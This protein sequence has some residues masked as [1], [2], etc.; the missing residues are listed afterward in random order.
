M[1]NVDYI[2]LKLQ[3][4]ACLNIVEADGDDEHNTNLTTAGEIANILMKGLRPDL[5]D[6]RFT[7]PNLPLP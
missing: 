3:M 1:K 2:M 6:P 7:E 4:S 5:I